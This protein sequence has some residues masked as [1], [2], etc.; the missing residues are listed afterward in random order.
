V[1]LP[2]IDDLKL[3][4][5]KTDDVDDL[6]L[7]D[8]LD[9]AV[10]VVGGLVGPL[11]SETVTDVHYGVAGQTLLLRRMPVAE[12]LEV[13]SRSVG[14][15]GFTELTLADY[16]LDTAAGALRMQTGGLFFGDI[17]VTYSVGRETVPAAIRLAVLIIAAHLW[18]TQRMPMQDSGPAGFGGM[19]GIPDAGSAGRGFAIPNRAQELLQSYMSPSIA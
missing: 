14:Y 17:S 13:S 9:A 5:N 6:E 10:E 15:S 1:S 7:T 4:L 19:D 12:V 3:H 16:E 18:E 8:V 2:S 11:D